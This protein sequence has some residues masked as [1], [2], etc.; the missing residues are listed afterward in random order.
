MFFSNSAWS[1]GVFNWCD[2]RLVSESYHSP[3][4]TLKKNLELFLQSRACFQAT[5]YF[6]CRLVGNL[7]DGSSSISQNDFTQLFF[8][9]S[10]V[11]VVQGHPERGWSADEIPPI[12]KRKNHSNFWV[13]RHLRRLFS[14]ISVFAFLNRKQN[15][16]TKRCLRK[17]AN[18]KN[19][20][21]AKQHTH[22]KKIFTNRTQH[23]AVTADWYT[24]W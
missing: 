10:L 21:R 7:F 15:F 2:C 16:T 17:S 12:L 9:C 4:M 5:L 3:V 13:K 19:H 20:E 1:F 23:S 18:K 14:R 24:Y 22:T 11:R 8:K 6:L